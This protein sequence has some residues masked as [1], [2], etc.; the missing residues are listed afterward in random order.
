[1]MKKR[2]EKAAMETI[3][4]NDVITMSDPVTAVENEQGENTG[5]PEE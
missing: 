2:Y 4:F 1:M 5:S 3:L